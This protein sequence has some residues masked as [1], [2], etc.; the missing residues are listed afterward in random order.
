MSHRRRASS[1]GGVAYEIVDL[2]T[3]KPL[4]D[5][6]LSESEGGLAVI[7]RRRGRPISFFMEELEPEVTMTSEELAELVALRAAEDILRAAVVDE[8]GGAPDP[9]PR[10]ELTVAVCTRNRPDLLRAC[11]EALA[12]VRDATPAHHCEI[13][14]VDNDPPDSRTA[15]L[16]RSLSGVQYDVERRR[17]L[18]FARNRAI[19]RTKTE[20]VAFVDDDVIVDSGWLSGI[21][22]AWGRF[23]DA[24]AVTGQVLP[25]ELATEAQIQFERLG[26]FRRDFDT[27][28]FAGQA[29]EGSTS[30]PT[31]PGMFGTGCNMAFRCDVV[32]RLGGFDEALDTGAPLPGGGDLDMFYRVIRAGHSLVYEPSALVFH[33]H[34]RGHE[35]LRR[36]YWTWGTGYMA[37]VH[38]T[39]RQDPSVRS[40]IR[41][42]L[43]WWVWERLVEL[44]RIFRGPSTASPDVVLAHLTGGVLSLLWMYPLSRRRIERLKRA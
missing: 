13:L 20:F 26:G 25:Y 22:T 30:Y 11:L 24:A 27:V 8:L 7:V 2:D 34:R 18:D 21:A 3:E 37:F 1:A 40:R 28:R 17:G 16:V 35:E 10:I 32:R 44:D 4:P 36:Q 6:H 19:A 39:Y 15:D 33:R 23:P 41:R 9:A 38:K 42:M 12:A 43:V 5:V 29:L 14:V 31:A